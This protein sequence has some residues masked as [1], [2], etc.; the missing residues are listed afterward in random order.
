MKVIIGGT[1]LARR[2]LLVYS[3]GEL[4]EI[5]SI[6]QR[7]LTIKYLW[8]SVSLEYFASNL[9]NISLLSL[10]ARKLLSEFRKNREYFF[11][12]CFLG[13]SVK[14]T[15]P[16]L[17]GELS[18]KVEDD[19]RRIWTSRVAINQG[20]RPESLNHSIEY[21]FSR[22]P[23]TYSAFVW[24]LN[25]SVNKN[26][27][28]SF[29]HIKTDLETREACITNKVV[30]GLLTFHEVNDCTIFYARTPIANDEIY[31]TDFYNFTDNSWPSDC[32]VKL[33]VNTFC[34]A[35]TRKERQFQES[36][37]FFGSSTGWFHFL[38][39]IF[40]R[41]LHFGPEK[42]KSLVPV[43]EYDTPAQILEAIN[44]ITTHQPIKLLPFEIGNF[45]NITLCIEARYPRGL[46][47]LN[48][49]LDILQVR[50][51]F[52]N[53]FI[54]SGADVD[55]KIFLLRK[56]N[57]FRHSSG[58]ASLSTFFSSLGFIVIDSGELS[59][60]EQIEIFSRA[61]LIVGET[62]SS[63]T[64]LL[65]CQKTCKIIEVNSSNFMPG[66]FADFASILDLRHIEVQDI[67]RAGDEI[68]VISK[69]KEVLLE[70]LIN[71][72]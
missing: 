57:L 72:L 21:D 20:V 35:D 38:I 12:R 13:Y 45:R 41:F 23:E 55:C 67:F 26:A 22:F 36:A 29:L 66:F 25:K 52:T 7:S 33:S 14:L 9:S 49:K 18:F 6:T 39:E 47:L 63:L 24:G 37:I 30:D 58:Y 17:T 5:L 31:P 43:V 46:D 71:E 1:G 34:I 70:N 50:E 19:S 69:G 60:I 68:K 16:S 2:N 27:R 8:Q 65:F 15:E 56:S 51:Y 64:N 54:L 61:S 28:K 42:M 44:T 62:G 32:P 3:D 53:R 59:M 11:D 4:I 10:V 40:P 48:R